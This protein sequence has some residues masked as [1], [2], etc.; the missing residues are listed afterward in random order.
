MMKRTG[1]IKMMVALLSCVG[2]LLPQ[3]LLAAPAG[4]QQPPALITDV[5][6]QDGGVFQ[7]TVVD[8]A[9]AAMTNT[10]VVVLKQGRTVAETATDDSG[11][12][13][14]GQLRGGTYQVVTARSSG[15]YRLWAPQTAP[16][17]A[18]TTALL[19][20]GGDVFR[21][22]MG[23]VG[24]FLTNRWVIVGIIGAAIAVPIAVHNR[25]SGS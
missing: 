24:M 16:P 23:P 9:G 5:E 3:T 14:I 6:L 18:R 21:G 15:V 17:A 12:F 4:P 11:R 20:E 2:M 22:Q 19:V 25:N 7:G 10:K 1:L 8:A 13:A